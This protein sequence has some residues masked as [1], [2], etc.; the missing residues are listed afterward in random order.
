MLS[1]PII[2][3]TQPLLTFISY[4]KIASFEMLSERDVKVTLILEVENM[5]PLNVE[6]MD[7]LSHP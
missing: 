2:K 1:L 6:N 4:D 5:V 3:A 7:I